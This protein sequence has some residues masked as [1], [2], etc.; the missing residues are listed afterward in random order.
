MTYVT[1]KGA[2]P[3]AFTKQQAQMVNEVKESVENLDAS[4]TQQET[5]NRLTDG[6]AAQGVILYNGQLYINASYI[7]T[8][9]LN[10]NHIQG[11]TLTLGG[12]NNQNGLL[13]VLN[14]AGQE[15]GTWT[16]DGIQISA[17]RIQ[18]SQETLTSSV[19]VIL[20]QSITEPFKII[21]NSNLG[22]IVTKLVGEFFSI[23]NTDNDCEIRFG[24][25]ELYLSD[26]STVWF[27]LSYNNGSPY[28]SIYGNA[29]I[30][31]D[32][33][34]KGN[35]TLDN[36]LTIGG[37]LSV[38]GTVTDKRILCATYALSIPSAG[39]TSTGYIT[40]LTSDHQ[41]V[42]WNFSDSP[43]NAPPADLEW[44]TFDGYF[45]ITNYGGTTSE[46]ITP[47]FIL[48]E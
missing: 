14:A 30:E 17:G 46:S 32:T 3:G 31:G 4:L 8:G 26:G 45:T 10:A 28:M 47:V 13:R 27:Y 43:E 44:E 48:P 5:F 40:G 42:R 20:Q 12:Q 29:F 21:Y 18:L 9:Y 23:K 2:Q 6:G 19:E 24:P 36:A 11:G 39:S 35:L 22:E 34:I 38:S 41:L 16:K 7:N 15:I 1:N 33:R 25:E 37:D